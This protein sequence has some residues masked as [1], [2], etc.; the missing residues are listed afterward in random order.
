MQ[1]WVGGYANVLNQAENATFSSVKR[2]EIRQ[3][4]LPGRTGKIIDKYSFTSEKWYFWR[5]RIGSI[6]KNTKR[7]GSRPCRDGFN[8]QYFSL[9]S[10]KTR[11]R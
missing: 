3:F 7:T 2:L 4:G 11:K 8:R 9:E 5:R 1:E 10:E 6:L